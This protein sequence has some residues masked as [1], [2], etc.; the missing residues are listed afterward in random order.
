M[1]VIGEHLANSIFL[2][3]VVGTA[4]GKL[5][6]SR[7]KF[8]FTFGDS[9]TTT[10]FNI[11]AGVDSPVPNFT[12]SNGPNWVQFLGDTYNVTNTKVFNL[13]SGGATID[14]ALV[15][16][17]LPTVL[18]IVDQVK[19]FNEILAPKPQGAQW[20]SSNSLFAFWIGINDVGNSFGWTNIT[21]P[22]FYDT[23]MDRLDTQI[24]NL[25]KQG[26]R[27]FLFLTV[28]PTDRAPLFLQQGP[29]ISKSLRGFNADYNV[30]LVRTIARFKARHRDLDQVNIFDTQPIFNLLLDNAKTLGFANSTGF[31]EVYQNGTPQ[32]TTQISPCAPVSS[33]F[34]LNSLHPLFTV[35]E[36]IAHGIS[37]LLSV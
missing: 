23:L 18:S 21:R 33:Y 16:P 36:S 37:T 10:G 31:C 25:Y 13:A 7:T 8:L 30:R 17:F 19:Q 20:D 12:S 4:F 5:T 34:W 9:Y 11:S 15:P 32:R 22:Q 24:E 3:S 14:G 26:A 1:E 27:S 35:H 29:A 2:Y 28:P 6:W